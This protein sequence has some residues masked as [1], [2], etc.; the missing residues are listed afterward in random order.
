MASIY[1][2]I[3]VAGVR[4]AIV[5]PTGACCTPTASL[6]GSHKTSLQL[7]GGNYGYHG[8]PPQACNGFFLPKRACFTSNHG[9][10]I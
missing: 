8:T 2:K 3:A 4:Q 9:I 5:I 7:A 10:K 1:A 6:C